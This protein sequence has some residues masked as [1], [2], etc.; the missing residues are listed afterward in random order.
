MSTP[1]IIEKKHDFNFEKVLILMN[2]LIV[3]KPRRNLEADVLR[4]N[5]A[6]VVVVVVAG[7]DDDDDDCLR[8]ERPLC[9][10]ILLL[11]IAGEEALITINSS[12]EIIN[13]NRIDSMFVVW[14]VQCIPHMYKGPNE[15]QDCLDLYIV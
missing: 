15:I 12:R 10:E 4:S 13:N 9:P 5:N 7:A 14:I 8:G 3:G 1:Y 2:C 6:V 11:S